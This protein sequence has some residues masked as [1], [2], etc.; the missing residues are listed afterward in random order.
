VRQNAQNFRAW[1]ELGWLETKAGNP[2]SARTAYEKALSIQPNFAPAQRD[3]GLLYFERRDYAQAAPHMLRASQLGL[4]DAKLF[5]FLGIC[6]DRTGRVPQA[7]VSYH[8]ALQLDDNLAE[9]HLNLGFAYEKLNRKSL[10]AREYQRAC[11]LRQDFCQI[12]KSRAR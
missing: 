12:V 6:Y 5:N 3:L 4:K 10:A 1:Y 2:D 11:R 8:D 9:A 7:I